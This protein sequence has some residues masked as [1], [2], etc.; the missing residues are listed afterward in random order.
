[1]LVSFPIRSARRVLRRPLVPAPHRDA[2]PGRRRRLP[3]RHRD[4]LLRNGTRGH[5]KN[6]GGEFGHR[7]GAGSRGSSPPSVRSG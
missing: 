6:V 4:N 1:M 5:L 7:Q 2:L 3:R